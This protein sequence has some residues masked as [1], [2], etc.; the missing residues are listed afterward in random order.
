MAKEMGAACNM[1]QHTK[2]GGGSMK[3][4]VPVH[5]YH[6][7]QLLHAEV[8]AMNAATKAPQARRSLERV[9]EIAERLDIFFTSNYRQSV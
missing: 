2:T 7:L 9:V 5:E 6:E 4:L 8:L 3:M 1:A